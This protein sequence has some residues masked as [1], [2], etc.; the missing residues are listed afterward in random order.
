MAGTVV[1]KSEI[2][3]EVV[4]ETIAWDIVEDLIDREALIY[5][6]SATRYTTKTISL[7]L[8]GVLSTALYDAV[9]DEQLLYDTIKDTKC[10]SATSSC[11]ISNPVARRRLQ[12]NNEYHF[13]LVIELDSTEYSS[14]DGVNIEDPAFIT[15]LESTLNLTHQ[16][17]YT[18]S[19]VDNDIIFQVTLVAES[20]NNDPL[21]EDL[22]DDI[23][24]I[25]SNLTAYASDLVDTLGV[26]GD[27]VTSTDLI[28]CPSE[29]DCNGQGLELC[30]NASGICDCGYFNNQWWWGIECE[31][32]CVCD[33]NRE[34]INAI[35]HC[36]FP[37]WG[38]R[39]HLNR[40]ECTQCLD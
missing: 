22:I 20:E 28:L 32:P 16:S 13:E 33:M 19:T 35:C 14:L 39:C 40:T 5:P 21:N 9:N 18:V 10:G 1:A 30:N 11:T 37:E 38:L 8:T 2:S 29:R 25:H 6:G 12:A 3:Y 27:W 31:T 34:C 7:T 4:N 17:S 24:A 15:A 23:R 26:N 36:V